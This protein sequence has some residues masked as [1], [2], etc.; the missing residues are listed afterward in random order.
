MRTSV[1]RMAPRI[2]VTRRSLLLGTL[3][4]ALAARVPRAG[5]ASP[6]ARRARAYRA[7][8]RRLRRA[9]GGH[10]RHADPAAAGRRFAAWYAGQPASGRAHADAVLDRLGGPQDPALTAAAVALAQ[11]GCDP[12]PAPD[13]RPTLP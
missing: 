6:A 12:P 3:A 9:P 10:F 2:E 1:T 11:I 8:V 7:L 5:A 13:D 4:A